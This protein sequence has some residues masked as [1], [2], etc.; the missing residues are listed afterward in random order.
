MTRR[1]RRSRRRSTSSHLGQR[2]LAWI[3]AAVAVLVALGW[4]D[5]SHLPSGLDDWVSGSTT[6]RQA[7]APGPSGPAA[8]PFSASDLEG[9]VTHVRDG[10]TLE[11]AGVPVRIAN[12]DC[13]ELATTE[14]ESARLFLS[15]LVDDQTLACDLEGRKSYDREVD[16]CAFAKTDEDLG[17][18]LI[19]EGVCG[20]WGG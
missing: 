18:I 8:P 14:G 16:T 1:P 15:D 19:E 3:T 13:A 5:P 10:D 11:V 17:E 7:P 12:L 9:R 4:L 6:S 2:P 20:R